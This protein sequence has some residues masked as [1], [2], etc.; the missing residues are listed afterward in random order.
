MDEIERKIKEIE[1]EILKTQKNKATEHHIGKLKAKL[2]KLREELKNKK[3]SSGGG[4]GFSIRKS[5]DATVGIAGL[6]NVGKSTILNCLTN[7]SS[8][9]GNY[10]FT[11]LDVIPGMMKHKG[12][13]IQ[14]L[15][16]PGLIVGASKGKGRGREILSASRNVDLL[17]IVV[18]ALAGKEQ[19]HNIINELHSAGVRCNQ[20]RPD[21]KIEKKGEGGLRVVKTVNMPD[22][23]NDT[24]KAIASE[25]LINAEIIIK[26]RITEEQLIDV[27]LGNRVYL[28]TIVVINKTDLI[29]RRTLKSLKEEISHNGWEVIDISATN[30]F[31]IEEL[32]DKIFSKLRFIRIYLKPAGGKPDFDRPMILNVGNTVK[33]V[34]EKLH[35]D[36]VDRFRYA[37]VWGKSVKYPGQK[38]GLDH[39]LEDKDILTI[40]IS[41]I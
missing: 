5:G 24:I 10:S 25:Y 41:H 18:D 34:C 20:K 26:E 39:I 29:D 33:T 1:D 6:P 14:I 3:S 27:L 40:S 13:V 31:G 28:P 4:K 2:A 22:L 11:T 9:V 32:K 12:A 30:G 35:M 37:Q 15:D 19:L 36:F 21:V 7:A 17:L 38:V 16:L 23:S 8:K